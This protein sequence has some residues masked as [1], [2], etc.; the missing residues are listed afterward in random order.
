MI[1][2]H[3]RIAV[4]VIFTLFIAATFSLL[5]VYQTQIT[6]AA[7][8]VAN[9][10]VVSLVQIT[11][12]NDT[13]TLGALQPGQQN[14][15][16]PPAQIKGKPG[17]FVVNNSGNIDV[18]ITISASQLFSTIAAASNY[19]MIR[20]GN[21]SGQATTDLP[22]TPWGA[23]CSDASSIGRVNMTINSTGWAAM[24]LSA[25]ASPNYV[26]L[27]FQTL[28]QIFFHINITVPPAEPVGNKTSTVT[29]TASAAW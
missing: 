26:N 14:S 23:N 22:Y 8:G 17:P 16:F 3:K 2:T 7:T 29:F 12:V 1:V 28:N 19:Y 10:T 21:A 27:S 13:V 4:I 25:P 15:T 9:V 5:N 20:C 24:P 11:L 18:N 6:G